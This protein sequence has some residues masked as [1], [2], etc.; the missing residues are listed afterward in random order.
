[1]STERQSCNRIAIE[2]PLNRYDERRAALARKT[3]AA[4]HHAERT[5]SRAISEQADALA[6]QALKTARLR[7]ARL[8]KEARENAA[9]YRGRR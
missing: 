7:A 6:E 3:A 1:M 9:T 2:V 8:D 5:I 4:A